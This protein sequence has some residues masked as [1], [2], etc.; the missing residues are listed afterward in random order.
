LNYYWKNYHY[1]RNYYEN[2]WNVGHDHDLI[3][4]SGRILNDEILHDQ[5]HGM[6][7][8]KNW[9]WSSMR[10]TKKTKRNWKKTRN[11]SRKKKNYLND[12]DYL[13]NYFQKKNSN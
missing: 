4:P 1:W 9:N 13:K 3:F 10:R 2:V 11:Y 5:N 6:N 7:E 12:D 8:K